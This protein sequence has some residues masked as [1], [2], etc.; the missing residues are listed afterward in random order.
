MI[1]RRVPRLC[2]TSFGIRSK[3]AAFCGAAFPA[4]L[5]LQDGDLALDLHAFEIVGGRI[6]MLAQ[7]RQIGSKPL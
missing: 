7:C 2:F 3:Q 6:K 4:V 1:R 5:F